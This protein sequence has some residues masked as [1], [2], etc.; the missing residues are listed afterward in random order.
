MFVTLWP[1]RDGGGADLTVELRQGDT[2][3]ASAKPSLPAA[4]QDDRVS[5]LGSIPA[6]RLTVGQYEIVVTARQGETQAQ[7]R[8]PIEIT[9]SAKPKP[10]RAS[11]DP[12]LLSLLE[13]AGRYVVE[14][15]Q[16]FKNIV[17]EE[18]YTQRVSGTKQ[19]P[20]ALP[21][22][23][24]QFEDG[25]LQVRTRA[26][27]VFVRLA[28]EIPWGVLRDVFE[29]NGVLVRDRDE[30]LQKLFL[31]PAASVRDQALR[32]VQESARFNMGPSR[33]LNIPTLA[34]LFLH[35][36]NQSR[37]SFKISGRRKF[38]GFEGVEVEFE[39]T[40]RPGIVSDGAGGSV[41]AS[42]RFW[43]EANRG[44]VL[45]SEVRYAF[46]P[47][48]GAGFVATEYRAEPSLGIFVPDEMKER[49]ADSP[50][51]RDPVF[52]GTADA[53]ARYTNLRRFGVSVESETVEIPTKAP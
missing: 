26:D 36:Q 15:E 24:V 51:T 35:P 33:T 13:R 41:P 14:Y 20:K 9:P 39:E 46:E 43:I 50:G 28:G 19:F 40:A 27:V 23:P 8:A 1:K 34:L 45:R 30:R 32:I 48:R 47:N 11:L 25:S 37:F 22:P 42:G 31:E 16:S 3:V 2:I 18:V 21:S 53:S 4:D 10:I 12:A 17:A 6:A 44:A 49:Y 52:G 7:E 38:H 29:A 5:W